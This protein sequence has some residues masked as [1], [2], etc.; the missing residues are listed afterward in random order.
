LAEKANH[1]KSSPLSLTQLLL[2][3]NFIS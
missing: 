3:R 1:K 2:N